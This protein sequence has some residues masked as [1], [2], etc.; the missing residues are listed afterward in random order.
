MARERLDRAA[1]RAGPWGS[2]LEAQKRGFVKDQCPPI[3]RDSFT[4]QA[5]VRSSRPC[6]GVAMLC[7]LSLNWCGG[8]TGPG[9]L[10]RWGGTVHADS[11]MHRCAATEPCAG[12][13]DAVVCR[14]GGLRHGAKERLAR[15]CLPGG[16]AGS[17][18][19]LRLRGG[20]RDPKKSRLNM[21]KAARR[22]A[23]PSGANEPL[24]GGEG[25][26]SMDD[27]ENVPAVG[28][29]G[30]GGETGGGGPRKGGVQ[31]MKERIRRGGAR[32]MRRW[33]RWG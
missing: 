32:R 16:A 3:R 11:N 14:S 28:G 5:V 9:P 22:K 33:V 23:G 15:G 26:G 30:E 1:V 8:C 13:Y 17:R 21:N 2:L 19:F 20:G 18:G 12:I 25:V 24:D 6:I 27:D 7:V 4:M 29:G 31:E 10:E